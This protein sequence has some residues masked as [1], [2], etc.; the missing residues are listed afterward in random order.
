[1]S[2]CSGADV[3]Q[4]Q[5]EKAQMGV[6][7]HRHGG[8]GFQGQAVHGQP[9]LGQ[10]AEQAVDYHLGQKSGDDSPMPILLPFDPGGCLF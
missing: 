4:R 1:M 10:G 5:V 6:P 2:G 9:R 7:R 3:H 8:N